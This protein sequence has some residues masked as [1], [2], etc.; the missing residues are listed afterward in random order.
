MSEIRNDLLYTKDHEWVRKGQTPHIIV[1]G[2]TDFAQASLGDVTYL[3][4]PEVGRVLKKGDIIGSIESVKAVSDIYAPVGGTVARVNE[5]LNADPAA[6]NS[7]PFGAGWLI[8]IES[9]NET[10]FVGLL[11]AQAYAQVAQ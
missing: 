10:D 7:D 5:A 4:M 1:M 9:W 8:E 3:Q 11:N 6:V 2:I